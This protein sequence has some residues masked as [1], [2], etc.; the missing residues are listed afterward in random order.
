MASDLLA[1][2]LLC[3]LLVLFDNALILSTQ[4][5][6]NGSQLWPAGRVHLH[7]HLIPGNTRLHLLK[8]L[9]EKK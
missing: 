5:R 8:F 3:M 6:Q 7:I 1:I 9:Q 2:P 4:V